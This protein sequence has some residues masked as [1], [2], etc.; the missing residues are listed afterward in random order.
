VRRGPGWGLFLC[1]AVVLKCCFF[2]LTVRTGPNW[3]TLVEK[4]VRADYFWQNNV[5]L[6]K[7]CRVDLFSKKQ[8][9]WPDKL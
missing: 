4:F 2:V 6:K 5:Y 8:T 1:V 3:D 7:L 9:G